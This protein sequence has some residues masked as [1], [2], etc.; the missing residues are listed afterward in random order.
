MATGQS[1][2]A[3]DG[4][5]IKGAA[6]VPQVVE[7]RNFGQLDNGKDYSFA[8][9]GAY[10]TTPP[11]MQALAA[12]LWT[13]LSNA[14]STHLALYMSSSTKFNRVEVR[15]M[16]NHLLPV[17]IGTGTAVVG[18]GVEMA[19]PADV[20]AVVTA[21]IQA[22]G[23]GMKGRVF[24]PGWTVLANNSGF[25][26][27]PVISALNAWGA[28]VIQA[29]TTQGLTACVAQVRRQDYTGLTGALIPARNAGHVVVSS[30]TCRNNEWDT[31]RRRGL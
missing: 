17:F 12:G 10:V 28:A 19:M 3:V 20:S 27:D 16:A 9:H 26:D 4:G 31:Q 5:H 7:I 25:I 1:V 8:L 11:D 22:R 23:K 24:I 6:D 15:D 30:Y 14:W 21:N 2:R 13:S 29:L 18:T